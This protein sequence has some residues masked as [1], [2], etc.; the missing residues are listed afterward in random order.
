MHFAGLRAECIMQ[1]RSKLPKVLKACVAGGLR[2]CIPARWL[3]GRCTQVDRGA[4]VTVSF[5]TPRDTDLDGLPEPL[6]QARLDDAQFRVAMVTNAASGHCPGARGS[7]APVL[8][9][10]QPLKLGPRVT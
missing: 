10:V 7:I 3:A 4:D 2:A 6:G 1:V 5:S 9:V 8:T